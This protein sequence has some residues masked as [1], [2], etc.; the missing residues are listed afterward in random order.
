MGKGCGVLKVKIIKC[1]IK[2]YKPCSRIYLTKN[3]S[4]CLVSFLWNLNMHWNLY[5]VSP[6]L[7]AST[8]VLVVTLVSGVFEFSF[9]SP[10]TVKVKRFWTRDS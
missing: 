5:V 7:N 6:F 2:Q 4:S 1:Q 9:D 8:M 10:K 3:D